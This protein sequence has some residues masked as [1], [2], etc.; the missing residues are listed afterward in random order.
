MLSVQHTSVDKLDT[1]E[2]KHIMELARI[3]LKNLI[4]TTQHLLQI[5]AKKKSTGSRKCDLWLME[6]LTVIKSDPESLLITCNELQ[7][8]S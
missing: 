3:T 6:K 8:F 2:T 7:S 1:N 5:K 4:R